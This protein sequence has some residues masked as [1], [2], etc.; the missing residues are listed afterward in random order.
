VNRRPG[1]ARRVGNGIALQGN[2][3]AVLFAGDDAIRRE[4]AVLPASARA[5]SSTPT[6]TSSASATA[7]AHTP[8]GAVATGQSGA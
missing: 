6:A 5:T 4:V 2:D 3:P 1:A 7:S 8:A